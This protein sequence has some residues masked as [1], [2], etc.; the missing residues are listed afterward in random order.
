MRVLVTG[1][2]GRVGRVAAVG[3]RE[4]GHTVR[5]H[6]VIDVPG[7]EDVWVSDLADYSSVLAATEGM[8]AI[9]HLGGD[10]GGG[11]FVQEAATATKVESDGSWQ[12]ILNA[13]IIG[14]HS[15]IPQ[16]LVTDVL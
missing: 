10:P 11:T 15:E 9:V 12:S 5:V 3:L 6:D 2:R 14:A 1:A 7:F 8:D 13:N 4:L 16:T